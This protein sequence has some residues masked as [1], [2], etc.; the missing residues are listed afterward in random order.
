MPDLILI[1]TLYLSA[2][3]SGDGELGNVTKASVGV[4]LF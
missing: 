4:V 3:L 2:V 1:M